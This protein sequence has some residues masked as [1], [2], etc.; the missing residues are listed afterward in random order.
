MVYNCLS[1]GH[2]SLPKVFPQLL[3]TEKQINERL[4]LLSGVDDL[5][6]ERKEQTICLNEVYYRIMHMYNGYIIV[7]SNDISIVD[8]VSLGP[9]V[10]R[11]QEAVKEYMS[12]IR[13]DKEIL[14]LT[15]EKPYVTNDGIT[16]AYYTFI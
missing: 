13:N 11:T 16:C 2:P 3:K 4:I 6:V 5:S 12:K 9:T 15:L 8:N 14:N 7:Y 10:F 1:S